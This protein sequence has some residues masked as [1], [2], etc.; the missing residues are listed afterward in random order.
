M[1]DYKLKDSGVTDRKLKD[2]K[3]KDLKNDIDEA[4]A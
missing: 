3:I 4:S 2:A 1:A